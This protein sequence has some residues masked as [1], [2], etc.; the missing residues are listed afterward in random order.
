ML[1]RLFHRSDSTEAWELGN[2]RR[3]YSSGPASQTGS[4]R[5]LAPGR[6]TSDELHAWSIY[7]QNLNSEFTD[8]ALGSSDKSPLP[9]GNFQ[10]RET[11]VNS[12]LQHPKYGPKSEL[13]ANMY[14]Y[15][16]YGLPRVFPPS[17]PDG[18]SGY[19]SSDDGGGGG[20]SERYRR[21]KSNPD[22]RGVGSAPPRAFGDS[23][24]RGR[25]PRSSSEA[26]LLSTDATVY[27]HSVRSPEAQSELAGQSVYTSQL[28]RRSQ[29][30]RA[31]SHASLG[32]RLSRGAA[33]GT[34]GF[35]R[36][37]DAANYGKEPPM[38]NDKLFPKDPA[39]EN[40]H[41]QLQVRE[42]TCERRDN[43][44]W[45][46]LVEGVTFEARGGDL[47]GIMTTAGERG[48]GSI[49]GS[50]EGEERLEAVWT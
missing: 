21:A 30:S 7:R 47:V 39:A 40:K 25:R 1:L 9:Y 38:L 15:L 18:S 16:K 8:S 43:G 22:L 41:P 32:S 31:G 26:N 37:G 11:T 45:K 2:M 10:L 33:L 23:V 49:R 6:P 13:G 19:D 4:T 42:M 48:G 27:N 50:G 36:R 44:A 28:E 24:F 17:R 3:K 12:I 14:T 34:A 46:R 29:R 5:H 20:R 35:S